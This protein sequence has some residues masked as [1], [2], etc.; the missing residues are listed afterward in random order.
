[1][2]S[3]VDHKAGQGT[4]RQ[5]E[6]VPVIRNHSLSSASMNLV[7]PPALGAGADE[8]WMATKSDHKAGQG[9]K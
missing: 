8:S 1:M 7:V 6:H 2:I 4:S 3:Q 9:E 5:V